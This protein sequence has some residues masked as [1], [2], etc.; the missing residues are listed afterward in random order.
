MKSNRINS[1]FFY[2]GLEREEYDLIKSKVWT[3][4]IHILSVTS[5][6]AAVM[7]LGFFVF[8][9]LTHSSVLFPYLFLFIGSSAVFI[10]NR[11]TLDR[12]MN[13]IF[14]IILCYS[15]MILVCVYAGI[16]STQPTN[17]AIPAT[18]IIV[19]IA[20]LPLSI[21]DRP[22][23]MYSMMILESGLYLVSSY[24]FKSREIFSLDVMNTA[25]F[26]V[27]GMIL[28]SVICSRNIREIY[29]GMRVESIQQSVIT[30]L[31][32]V[33]EERDENTGGHITRTEDY[34]KNLILQMKKQE[35]YSNLTD[36]YYKNVVLAAPMHDIGKIKIPDAIL[37]KPGRL[38]GEEFEVMKKHAEYGTEIIKKTMQDVEKEEYFNIACNIAK[39][40]H[41]R[42]DGT[43]YPSGLKG[44]E[45]PVEARIMALAD[46]YDALVSERVYK[47]AFSK[48][49]ARK[50]IEEGV[51]TQFDPDLASLFL[52]TIG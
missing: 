37:N 26:C 1:Y 49:E 29:Q 52:S 33:V 32:T 20:L 39:Y 35:K 27:V 41:E 51:G 17:Y 9:T 24:F 16:L 50:I 18:S 13:V 30:S 47:R 4:N 19:F 12:K 36:E 6:L 15:Q 11:I 10:L 3:R 31:A 45:I 22:A 48:E 42:F 8:N 25:T 40:H 14:R 46:V 38:T 34:V 43:G 21:D 7:G 5:I 28:Y 44:E 2:C 23:R